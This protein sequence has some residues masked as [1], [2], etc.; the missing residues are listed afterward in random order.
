MLAEKKNSKLFKNIDSDSVENQFKAS[1]NIIECPSYYE[2]RIELFSVVLQRLKGLRNLFADWFCNLFF[3]FSDVI[4]M[5][6]HELLMDSW[7]LF[8]YKGMVHYT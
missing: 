6:S 4:P 8:R 5:I 1:K 2:N 7:I 3:S